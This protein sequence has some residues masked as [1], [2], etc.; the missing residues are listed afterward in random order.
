MTLNRYVEMIV[1]GIPPLSLAKAKANSLTSLKA[2]GG[3]GLGVNAI[4]SEYTEVEYIESTGEQY[5][6]TGIPTQDGIGFDVTFLTNS[7][8]GNT[9]NYG[10][11]LGGRKASGNNDFQITTFGTPAGNIRYGSQTGNNA[12]IVNNQKLHVSLINRVVTLNDETTYTVSN[13]T[14]TESNNVYLFGL[15]NSG[16]LAQTGLGCRIY[17]AKLYVGSN[18][19]ADFIPVKRKSDN[20]LGMYDATSGRFLTNQGTGTFTAGSEVM[21]TPSDPMDIYCNNGK[22]KILDRDDFVIKTG[23]LINT[24]GKWRNTGDTSTSIVV[25]LTVGKKYTMLINKNGVSLG[26]VFRYGQS[27]V[28]TAT[29]SGIQ[30]KDWFYDSGDGLQDGVMVSITA[31]QPYFVL[32]VTSTAAT[33]VVAKVLYF[34]EAEGDYTFLKHINATGTQYIETDISGF[35]R[36]VGAGQGSSVTNSSKCILGA[37]TYIGSQGTGALTYLAGRYGSGDSGKFWTLGG[38]GQNIG[39][40]TTPTTDY[41]E[42]DIDFGSSSYEGKINQEKLP[43]VTNQFNIGKWY[44]GCT[45]TASSDVTSYKFVGKIYRQKA[46]QNGIL[47]GDFI[48][49]IRNSDSAIGMLDIVSGTFYENAGTGTFGAGDIIGSGEAISIDPK[50]DL[51]TANNLFAINTYKDVQE[52]ITGATTHNCGVLLLNGDENWIEQGGHYVYQDNS[53]IRLASDVGGVSNYFAVKDF[54]LSE[55]ST[56]IMWATNNI[57]VVSPEATVADF[58]TW[59][60]SHPVIIVYARNTPYDEPAP[61]AQSMTVVD[62]DNTV[63]L[64]QQG[65]TPLELEATYTKKL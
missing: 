35:T 47:V 21:P 23:C 46:Y 20:V 37:A 54:N 39:V 42:Y 63:S 18:V 30:L 5:I 7:N 62:G 36:W 32:Q 44:I 48:P 60:A 56:C 28:D 17:N 50:G 8:I 19:V 4:P 27:S 15:N 16:T 9:G 34:I 53:A 43:I 13:Y 61:I 59:L 25:P 31:K 45:Y 22:I 52:I 11:I 64:I 49:A 65:M 33:N 57:R 51:A 3:T 24:E 10:C 1:S 2:F 14:F 55:S 12:G 41:A 58:K 38:T 26:T 29:S 40:S 6:N